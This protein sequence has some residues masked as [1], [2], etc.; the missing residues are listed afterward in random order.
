MTEK[1][2]VTPEEVAWAQGWNAG[3]L[4]HGRPASESADDAARVAAILLLDAATRRD[5]YDRGRAWTSELGDYAMTIARWKH[6]NPDRTLPE[7]DAW[8]RYYESGQVRDDWFPTGIHFQQPG[9]P[10]RI[11]RSGRRWD[12]DLTESRE[13]PEI[14]EAE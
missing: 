3:W 5:T 2:W 10:W 6:E 9:E 11:D 1:N 14:E 4:A 13:Q 7:I 12:A 8:D